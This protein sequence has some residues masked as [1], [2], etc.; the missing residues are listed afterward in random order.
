[1]QRVLNHEPAASQPCA[2]IAVIFREGPSYRS[3][4]LVPRTS[5]QAD[6]AITGLGKWQVQLAQPR[7]CRRALELQFA[8]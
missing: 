1:M 3:G 8:S 4:L 5:K 7:R 6:V 2:N